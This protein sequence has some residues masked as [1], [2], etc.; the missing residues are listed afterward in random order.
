MV[1][2]GKIDWACHANDA[3]SAIGE[4]LALSKAVDV[5]LDFYQKHPKDTLILVTGDHETGGLS[6]GF[7]NTNYNTFLGNFLSQKISYA[8]FDTDYVTNYKRDDRSFTDVLSDIKTNFGLMTSNDNDANQNNQLVLTEHEYQLLEEAYKKTLNG[9]SV[10][11]Q[12]EL[13]RYG[14]YEPL[15]VTITHLLNNKSGI[16]YSTYSHSGAPVGV[17]AKGVGANQFSGYYDNTDINR[18]LVKLLRV[19]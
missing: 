18:T 5:A 7:S 3:G 16:N 12:E 17:F 4:T 10:L 1:E 9:K 2:S 14:S 19:K 8:K 11:T 15:T 6:I 13:T